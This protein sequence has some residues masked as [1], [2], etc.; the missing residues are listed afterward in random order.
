VYWAEE[1]AVSGVGLS[2]SGV[3]LASNRNEYQKSKVQ[4]MHRADNLATICEPIV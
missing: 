4:L 1:L 3:Y 2:V